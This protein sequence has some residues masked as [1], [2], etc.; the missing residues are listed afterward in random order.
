MQTIA[1]LAL[2]VF[3]GVLFGLLLAVVDAEADMRGEG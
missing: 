2:C 3:V 1:V